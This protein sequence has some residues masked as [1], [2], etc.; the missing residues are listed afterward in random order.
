[1]SE[2]NYLSTPILVLAGI[3]ALSMIVAGTGMMISAP[4]NASNHVVDGVTLSFEDVDTS[5]TGVEDHTNW[6]TGEVYR[7]VVYDLGIKMQSNAVYD[8]VV[9]QIEITKVG[10]INTTDL[11]VQYYEIAD[12]SWHTLIFTD[13]GDTLTT[14]FG[15]AEGFSVTNGYDVT[16]YFLADYTVKGDYG[17]IIWAEAI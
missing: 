6:A 5:S 13:E 15:P 11:N 17:I 7:N 1:M 10:G 14:T 3:V 16:A 8:A 2:K 9:V 12:T 4:L